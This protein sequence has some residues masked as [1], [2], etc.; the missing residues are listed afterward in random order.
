MLCHG[1]SFIA[2]G[3]SRNGASPPDTSTAPGARPA[4]MTIQDEGSFCFFEGG[5]LDPG[6]RRFSPP[7]QAKDGPGR[8]HS[9]RL[10]CLQGSGSPRG[11]SRCCMLCRMSCA[12]ESSLETRKVW[13][14]LIGALRHGGTDRGTRDQACS[15]PIPPLPWDQILRH[16]TLVSQVVSPVCKEEAP[17]GSLA[18]TCICNLISQ[19]MGSWRWDG[20]RLFEWQQP[21]E[22]QQSARAPW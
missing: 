5:F 9:V 16:R 6:T 17:G 8:A 18:T 15:T 21:T 4:K 19:T 2:T 20:Q 1:E 11:G 10:S 22:S 14:G 12:A 3:R 7:A 13:V